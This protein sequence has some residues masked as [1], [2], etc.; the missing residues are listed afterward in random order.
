MKNGFTLIELMVALALLGIILIAL[1]NATVVA[2]RHNAYI[3]HRKVA[4]ELAQ[5]KLNELTSL[6]SEQLNSGEENKTISP[7]T[8]GI[9]WA[10]TTTSSPSGKD[11][12]ITA[13]WQEMGKNHSI[14]LNTWKG[15]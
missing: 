9:S 11:I 7:I 3:E 6:P 14:I 2:I 4:L 5:S 15:S 13:S 8:Y 10:V 1:T 12:K